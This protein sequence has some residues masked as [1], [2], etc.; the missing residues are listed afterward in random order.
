MVLEG[1]MHLSVSKVGVAGEEFYRGPTVGAKC[2]GE[3]F[4][5]VTLFKIDNGYKYDQRKIMIIYR[6]YK[7]KKM[8]LLSVMLCRASFVSPSPLGGGPIYRVLLTPWSM[9]STFSFI[10]ASWVEV[11]GYFFHVVEIME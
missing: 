6:N 7:N 5:G 3:H 11:D 10:A 1:M 8:Y 9:F 2:S 4:R